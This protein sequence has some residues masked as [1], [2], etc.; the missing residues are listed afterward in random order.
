ML[1]GT[2]KFPC[3]FITKEVKMFLIGLLLLIIN[4]TESTFSVVIF[5]IGIALGLAPLLVD[6]FTSE[7]TYNMKLPK[8][9]SKYIYKHTKMNMVSCI[10]LY[11]TLLILNDLAF[12]LI[13]LIKFIYWITHVGR[14][15]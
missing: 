3:P 15:D 7:Y 5:S 4:G 1:K 9:N 12:I 13:K 6:A 8:M 11:H 10:V 2:G 14:E